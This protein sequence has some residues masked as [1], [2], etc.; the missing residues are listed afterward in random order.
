MGGALARGFVAAGALAGDALRF[1]DRPSTREI[2]A[3]LGAHIAPT[4]AETVAPADIVLLGVKP[5]T[6][7]S[8]L[9][10]IAP[11]L[12]SHTLLIS[13]AAGVTLSTIEATLA[14]GQPVIRAMPNTP[15]L[16]GEGATGFCRGSAAQ[17]VHA[18]YAQRLFGA[19]GVCSEVTEAL[20]DAVIGVSGSGVAYAYLFLEALIDGG[21]REGLP[22]PVARQLAAQ[23]LAGAARMVQQ[24]GEHPAVLKDAVTTPGGTTIAALET[25]E[26]AALRGAVIG[27]V[28][29]AA[30]RARELG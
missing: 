6:L 9:A 18:E 30:Q 3:T 17:D 19:V 23:T 7:P 10:Q 27:A 12:S 2:A 14:P 20:I 28:R 24:T 25:L 29:A 8:V 13:V 21:V 26:Q 5:T 22:R 1:P 4:N 16:I 11:H 15:A